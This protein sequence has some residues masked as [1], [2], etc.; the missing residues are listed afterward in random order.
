MKIG[1]TAGAFDLLH[2]GHVLMLEEAKSQCDYLLVG[3]QNDPTIDRPEKNKPVQSFEERR[4]QL[5][6]VRFV[7]EVIEYDTEEDLLEILQTTEINVRI[8]GADY[9]GKDFTG[10]QLCE[11]SGIEVYYNDRSHSYSST[12]LRNRVKAAN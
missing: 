2:A 6:A 8:V 9:I 1:F 12:E 10:K 7:D 3:L 11:V 4:I 5:A